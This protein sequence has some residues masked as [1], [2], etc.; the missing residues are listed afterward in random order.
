M[1]AHPA[2]DE[3]APSVSK[4]YDPRVRAV[5][6]QAMLAAAIVA[7][8]WGAG[9]FAVENMARLGIPLNFA[10]WNQ[11]AGFEINQSLI[12][13]SALSTYGE[14]FWVGLINTLLVSAVGIVFATAVGFLVAILRLAPNW[15][16]AKLATVYVEVFRNI[17][18][19]LQ[20]IFW[21]TVVLKSLPA[22]RQSVSVF[23]VV[24]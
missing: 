11:T 24:S 21:Y 6:Y 13:Y 5:V 18:L 22:P 20:L 9:H 14:A 4:L 15:I 7:V 19:L 2:R 3:A 23:G 10:F 12:S 17:P 1:S 8:L 16:V